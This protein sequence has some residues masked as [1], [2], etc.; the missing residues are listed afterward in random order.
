MPKQ[1]FV[2]FRAVKAAVS[3]ERVLDHSSLSTEQ[4]DLILKHTSPGTVIAQ[5]Q[6]GIKRPSIDGHK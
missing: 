4:E 2:D 3:L 1:T 6:S 5:I